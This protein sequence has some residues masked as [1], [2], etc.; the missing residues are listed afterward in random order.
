LSIFTIFYRFSRF[1]H[2]CRNLHFVAIYALC[3]QFFFGQNSLPRNITR[4]LHVWEQV[5]TICT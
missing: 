4:F 2:F 5:G 3:P 1:T